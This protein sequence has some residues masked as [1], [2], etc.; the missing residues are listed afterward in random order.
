MN[1]YFQY[2]FIY[3]THTTLTT[4][5]NYESNFASMEFNDLP[6]LLAIL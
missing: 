2:Y 1:V 3:S 6:T 4:L 5:N